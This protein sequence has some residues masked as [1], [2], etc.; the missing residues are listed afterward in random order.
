[1][2]KTARLAGKKEFE[3]VFT[4]G[5]AWANSFVAL[6]ALPNGLG[7]NRYSVVAGKR[8]GKA[9]VRNRIKRRLREV[10]RQ[11]SVREGWDMVLMARQASVNA[12]YGTL[13]KAT[14][15]LLTRARLLGEGE[16]TE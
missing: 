11:I 14:R 3:S 16:S 13:E 1:M 2:K 6:R 7:V 9:V 12:D 4:E 15:E 10:V 5:R 8:L